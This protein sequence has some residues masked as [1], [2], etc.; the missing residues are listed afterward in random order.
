MTKSLSFQCNILRIKKAKNKQTAAQSNLPFDDGNR[1]QARVSVRKISCED[2]FVWQCCSWCE[3]SCSLAGK[4]VTVRAPA[5]ALASLTKPRHSSRPLL[6]NIKRGVGMSKPKKC[7]FASNGKSV[8][9]AQERPLRERVTHRLAL[10]P[11][12]RPELILR[13]QKDGLAA[14][15]K[16]MLDSVLMEVI[17][18]PLKYPRRKLLR[19]ER[20]IVINCQK[21]S[22]CTCT[23]CW[24]QILLD[25]LLFSI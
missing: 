7:A 1:W 12:K 2:I 14:G 15:D 24:L 8:G 3:I 22:F 25:S 19:L 18:S 13:L 6:D 17:K 16:D 23:F 10:R 11:Y 4:K 21:L 5:P 20:K 9:E